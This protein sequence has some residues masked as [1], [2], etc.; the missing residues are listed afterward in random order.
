MVSRIRNVE[1]V[2]VGQILAGLGRDRGNRAKA[3]LERRLTIDVATR[4]LEGRS[5]VAS[6]RV[7]DELVVRN[8]LDRK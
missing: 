7:D 4:L 1:N 2:L 8:T 6:H 3:L 5:R